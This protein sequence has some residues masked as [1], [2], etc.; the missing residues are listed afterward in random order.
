[1]PEP[2]VAIDTATTAA[3]GNFTKNPSPNGQLAKVLQVRS[4]AR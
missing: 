3:P 4:G 1:M 2:R